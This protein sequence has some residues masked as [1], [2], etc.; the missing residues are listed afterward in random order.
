MGAQFVELD[1][2]EPCGG[3]G[4]ST[5]I[6]Q[7]LATEPGAGYTLSFFFSAR[8][9]VS[10]VDNV[11][12]VKWNGATIATLQADGT[13]LSD[14]AWTLH[15]YQVQATSSSTR[16]EFDDGGISNGAGTY[17]DGVSVVGSSSTM[18]AKMFVV[19]S[20]PFGLP[21]S[22]PVLR[23]SVSGP[24]GTPTLETTITDPTFDLPIGVVFTPLGEMLV[25]NRGDGVSPGAGSITRIA[26][27]SG[28]PSPNGTITSPS[29]SGAHFGA[30]RQNELFVAQRG[31]SDVIRFLFDAA[32]NPSFNGTITQ[33]LC[34]TA[35]R[36][37]AVSPSGEL[38]VSQCCGVD[39]I[40][41]YL[42]DAAGNAVP[43][44]V[45]TGGG[46]NN[47]HD[48]VFSPW[49]E[50]FVANNQGNSVSRFTF[51]AAGN[52][53]PN[54]VLTGPTLSYPTGLD[55]SPWGELFVA[56][57][58]PP[59]GISRWTFDSSH[60]ATF[61]GFFSTPTTVGDVEFGPSA[62]VNPPP[63][64]GDCPQHITTNVDFAP[65]NPE[66]TVDLKIDGQRVAG[67]V[68]DGGT[69]GPIDVE[70]GDHVITETGISLQSYTGSILCTGES[71]P[72]PLPHT[73]TVT[74]Q[75][76]VTCTITNTKLQATAPARPR[77][78]RH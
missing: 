24:T 27:P 66:A 48:M 30:F 21:N 50:L 6:F 19:L 74:R 8:P 54:G 72:S 36:G 29:F 77:H 12:I 20:D 37:V 76:D 69:S 38:F 2:F 51:D 4:A 9:T 22:G 26:N 57:L 53:S 45:I 71:S 60:T 58:G 28:V 46:L 17:L 63:C 61:N 70:P 10:A 23:Y 47:P 52:A 35:P 43:N 32:G 68:H 67:V 1:S 31:G 34:C 39:E 13:F 15:S 62:Q 5:G 14:T 3:C 65:A 64:S 41:R 11:L 42:L 49:G 55:F 25:I 44:G 18:A 56:N 40:D 16:L 33:G 75:T 59:G 73:V 78:K 7:D